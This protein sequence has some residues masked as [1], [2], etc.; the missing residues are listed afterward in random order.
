MTDYLTFASNTLAFRAEQALLASGMA[1]QVVPRPPG[2]VG[3][4][5]LALRLPP[6]SLGAA[7][8]ALAARRIPI[9]KIHAVPA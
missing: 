2:I 6:G 9:L 4:C 1:V 5:A 7:K 8:E 3:R